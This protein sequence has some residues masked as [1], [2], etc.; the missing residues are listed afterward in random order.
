M[1]MLFCLCVVWGLACPLFA[2]T[3]YLQP[4]S[5]LPTQTIYDML[6]DRQGRIYLG[7]DKGLF[8]FNGKNAWLI[9]FEDAQ[10]ADFTALREDKQGRIWGLNF[11][12]QLFYLENDTLRTFPFSAG[13]PEGRLMNFDFTEKC[14]WIAT[15]N[16]LLAYNLQDFKLVFSKKFEVHLVDVISYQNHIKLYAS[17]FVFTID[18]QMQFSSETT[19]FT[20]ESQFFLQKDKLY[21]LQRKESPHNY[22]IWDSPTQPFRMQ[23]LNF[24]PS[25]FLYYARATHEKTWLCTRQG[26]YLFE[27][28]LGKTTLVF[29][30]KDISDIIQDFQ[31]NYWISTLNEGLWFCTDLQNMYYPLEPLKNTSIELQSLFAQGENLY[32]GLTN[33]HIWQASQ[34]QP[35][36]WRDIGKFSKEGIRRVSFHPTLPLFAT[37]KGVFDLQGQP[38]ISF[39]EYVLK[40]AHF[41]TV[42]KRELLL[43]TFFFRYYWVD[44]DLPPSLPPNW[45]E[46]Q[47]SPS[48]KWRG[49]GERSKTSLFP[50][51]RLGGLDLDSIRSRD[52]QRS[53]Y[54]TKVIPQRYYCAVADVANQKYW[55]ATD[56]G[57]FAYDSVGKE[58]HLK[59]SGKPIIARQLLTDGQ[60]RLWVS[61]FQQGVFVIENQRVVAHLRAGKELKSNFIRKMILQDD[62]VWISTDAEIGY[63]DIQNFQF[64]EILPQQG[65]DFCITEKGLWIALSQGIVFMAGGQARSSSIP[66]LLPIRKVGKATFAVEALHYKNPTEIALHYRLKGKNWRT[67]QELQTLLDYSELSKGEYEIEVFAQD[68]T[69]KARSKTQIIHF[70]I[71]ARWWETWWWYAIVLA[72]VGA[73]I[74]GLTYLFFE[75]KRKKQLLKEQLWISQLK[76]LRAQMNPHFL[77]NILNTVQGLVYSNRKT[78]AG[79]LLGNFSDLMRKSLESSENAYISLR[80]ELEMVGLYLLLEKA[81]FDDSFR[82]D[83][84]YENLSDYMHLKI[85]SMLVQPFV[86]NALKHGLLHKKGDKYLRVHF[87]MQPETT[88]HKLTV[89]IDDNGIGRKASAEINQRKKNKSTGFATRATAQRIALLNLDKKNHITWQIH[90][91]PQGTKVEIVIHI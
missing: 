72:T 7:T 42:G 45:R 13:E 64:Q 21:C 46:E 5:N 59:A 52:F 91:K 87:D 63:A 41:Y 90:D 75:R 39:K 1:K 50:L 4:T 26:G 76:A 61:T 23:K 34:T 78:E 43:I 40:D 29:P 44:L 77:Y 85:P 16:T 49:V 57:L 18:E 89:T 6:S 82:Y 28:A 37:N 27:P 48:P 33:G 3:P 88:Q 51:R 70:K 65:R 60:A 35:T 22:M 53:A 55:V 56:N 20:G 66:R 69:T 19:T 73:L 9:P 8:R 79:E 58:T 67:I 10:Q 17:H 36:K 86:E 14:V 38:I 62:K 24:P 12:K 30:E 54:T 80:E 2:Q 15:S 71:P 25:V 83:L 81:R 74:F 32:A 47:K 68:E 84:A 31:G 11:A